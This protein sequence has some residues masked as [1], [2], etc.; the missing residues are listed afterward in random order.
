MFINVIF[1]S[2]LRLVC[3]ID[4]EVSDP[5]QNIDITVQVDEKSMESG[6]FIS[7]KAIIQGF[8]F[9]VMSKTFSTF[10]YYTRLYDLT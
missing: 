8:S 1:H 4:S 10:N 7:G 5:E 9:V 6:Y 2:F 3:R